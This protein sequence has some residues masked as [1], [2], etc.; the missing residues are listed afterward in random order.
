MQSAAF[1]DRR[2]V[3]WCHLCNCG[4]LLTCLMCIDGSG[5]AAHDSSTGT[6]CCN[7]YLL[8]SG[9]GAGRGSALASCFFL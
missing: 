7:A 3:D 9:E 4:N 2:D 1:P 6:G 8:E 5:P